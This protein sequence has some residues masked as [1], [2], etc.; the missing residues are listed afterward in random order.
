MCSIW[1]ESCEDAVNK[2]INVEYRASYQYHLIWTY[3]ARS[4]IGLN[5]IA[6]YF[7]NAALEEREHAE[8]LMEYQCMRGGKVVLSSIESGSLAYLNQTEDNSNSILLSFNKALEMEQMVY[9][10]LLKL[11]KV[12]EDC[13]DPQF[14]DFVEG[15]FL[16]EQVN[17][18]HEVKKYIAQL[19]LIGNSGQGL[20][21]FDR[22]LENK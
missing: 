8:K 1:N 16:E 5:N 9:T 18:I 7:K 17:A 10:E 12:A 2:Q 3:F 6:T 4:D 19:K 13:N 15:E 22:L 14:S 20:W 11:H 21:E